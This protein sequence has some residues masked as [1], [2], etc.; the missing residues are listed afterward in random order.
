MIQQ[1]WQGIISGT[2]FN[3]SPPLVDIVTLNNQSSQDKTL[4]REPSFMYDTSV[5]AFDT[6]GT[7]ID[8][9]AGDVIEELAG[10][11]EVI[12]FIQENTPSEQ[13]QVEKFEYLEITEEPEPEEGGQEF[14][15]EQSSAVEVPRSLGPSRRLSN[16]SL[17]GGSKISTT[18]EGEKYF[19]KREESFVTKVAAGEL[20]SLAVE[21]SDFCNLQHSPSEQSLSVKPME[22]SPETEIVVADLGS[23]SNLTV[24]PLEKSKSSVQCSSYEQIYEA[25][26]LEDP[27]DLEKKQQV[28]AEEILA[29]LEGKFEGPR[30]VP[31][32]FSS[33]EE[34]YSKS[35]AGAGPTP[36]SEPV[37]RWSAPGGSLEAPILDEEE[38]SNRFGPISEAI[39]QHWTDMEV[40]MD[41]QTLTGKG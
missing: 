40:L 18:P 15:P 13:S 38:F 1:T 41:T 6:K 34:L 12:Q 30:D 25:I 2:L 32:Y 21:I 26:Q 35:G 16:I 5:E 36:T 33:F 20:A 39:S 8:D 22:F 27:A 17:E 4:S 24:K 37:V 10:E 23:Q 9:I 29:S 31:E 14:K 28:S 11:D 7:D 19:M 3:C